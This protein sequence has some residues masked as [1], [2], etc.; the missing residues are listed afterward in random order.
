MH[1]SFCHRGLYGSTEEDDMGANDRYVEKSASTRDIQTLERSV[2]LGGSASLVLAAQ[3]LS[4]TNVIAARD[5][6]SARAMAV[7]VETFYDKLT[8]EPLAVAAQLASDVSQAPM[9]LYAQQQ[10][11][12]SMRFSA[13][14]EVDAMQASS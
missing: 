13:R 12:P 10:N 9:K 5:M 4:V 6:V 11:L 2:V 7:W 1:G 8:Q 14:S 3:L